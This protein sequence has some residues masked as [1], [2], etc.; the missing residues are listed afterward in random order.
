M[1]EVNFLKIDTYNISKFLLSYFAFIV[2]TTSLFLFFGVAVSNINLLISLVISVLFTYSKNKSWLNTA[3]IVLIS[4]GIFALCILLSMVVYDNSYDGAA[5]HKQAVG[6]LKE[7]WIPVYQSAPEFNQLANSIAF[8]S[9]NPM[10]WADVYPKATWYFAASI[11]SLV[12][13]IEAG[14]AYTLLFMFITFGFLYDYLKS[15]N[16]KSWQATVVSLIAILNPI[17]LSQFQTYYLDGAVS[18]IL[19]CLLLM[20]IVY[21]EKGNEGRKSDVFEI[22][23]FLIVIGCNTKFSVL[24]F[25]GV[26]CICFFLFVLWRSTLLKS[27]K[28][29]LYFLSAAAF[30][31]TVVGF[32]PIF[33]NYIKYRNPLY[34]FIGSSHNLVSKDNMESVFGIPGLNNAQMFLASIFGKTSHGEY[35]T[36]GSLLKLPFTYYK[37]EFIYYNIP[38]PRIGGFGFLFSGILI[39]SLAILVGWIISRKK[40]TIISLFIIILSVVSILEMILLP[41]TYQV[42]YIPQ[43]YFF[44]VMAVVIC[45]L[46]FNNFQ[47]YKKVATRVYFFFLCTVIAINILPYA[48]V[49]INRINKSVDTTATLHYL[50]DISKNTTLS[51]AFWEY[52]FT[53]MH[54]NLKDFGI[55]N[56]NFITKDKV[57][58][59]FHRTYSNWIYYKLEK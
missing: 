47:G 22:I 1:K 2:I 17:T 40:K 34:G 33:T 54:Y 10:L 50:S 16:I 23:F 25:I 45:S 9:D 30:S 20:F 56:Y 44:V 19:L 36:L 5:Y 55:T 51:I 42:R 39:L 53:G 8:P 43:L 37:G 4:I 24:L 12:D 29:F 49:S 58:E 18:C 15:K 26:Y 28:M 38:D 32:S 31:L 41:T 11:Y 46:Y 59:S 35:K 14:K 48:K 52:D 3:K 57:D 27:L 21:L 13:N 6:F 7:G